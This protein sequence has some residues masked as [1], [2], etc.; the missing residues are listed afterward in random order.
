LLRL[1]RQYRAETVAT[2]RLLADGAILRG[3]AGELAQV[4]RRAEG[5]AWTHDLAARGLAALRIVGTIALSQRAGQTRAALR[6]PAHEGQV[7]V[8]GG[9]LRGKK[10][11]VS[12][13][14]TA[15]TIGQELAAAEHGKHRESL[16]VLQAA[17]KHFT[18]A[19]FGRDDKIDG[20]VLSESLRDIVPVV[21]RLR[22]E[23]LWLVRK[24]NDA[25]EFAVELGNRAWSR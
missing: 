10:V 21:R 8:R 23:H 19:Q 4:R 5:E 3:A 15:E 16:E 13:S 20:D 25:T 9:W 24:F 2:R 22:F 18:V 14:A 17:L 7:V 1:L 6:K 11:F 12:G